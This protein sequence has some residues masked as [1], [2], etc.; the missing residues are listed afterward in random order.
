MACGIVQ[1]CL[2]LYVVY[3]REPNDTPSGTPGEPPKNST[4]LLLLGTIA[5]TTWRMFIP[6][7]GLLLLGVWI[8]KRYDTL[9]WAT[10]LLT[11]IGIAIA[12]QLI[13]RQLT[14]VNK[15]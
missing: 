8:D 6:V 1:N 5:D 11:L 12:A 13:R 3:M 9:P 2:V 15:K 7:I 14:N 10:L 4:V